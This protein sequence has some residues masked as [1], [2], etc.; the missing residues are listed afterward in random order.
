MKRFRSAVFAVLGLFLALA[1]VPAA[2]ADLLVSDLDTAV[3]RYDDSGA[4]VGVFASGGGLD[5]PLGLA[6]G[7]G[8]DLFVASN[9]TDQ[10]LRFDGR[11]GAFIGVFASDAGLSEPSGLAFGPD[12]DLY[13]ATIGLNQ[14]LRFDGDTGA[15]EGVFASGGGLSEPTGLLF[16]LDL[17]TGGSELFVAS[18]GSNEV[19]RYDNSG[20]FVCVAASGGGLVGPGGLTFGR[21]GNLLVSGGDEVLRFDS[22]TGAF[23]GV[24]ASGSGLV[25]PIGL[26]FGPGGDLFV[27]SFD[28]R[29]VLRFDGGTGTFEGVFASGGGLGSPTF[30]IFTPISTS[31]QGYAMGWIRQTFRDGTSLVWHN[32]GIDGFTTFIGFLPERD[33]GL[34]VLNNMNPVAIGSFFYL[35]VLNHLLS[36]R[37]GLN[38]GVNQR[39][40]A[41]Y[42]EAVA[43]TRRNLEA[44]DPCR[45][46][47]GGLVRR[48]LPGG[49]RLLFDEGVLQIRVGA[50]VMPLRALRDGAYVTT[51]GLI[52]GLPVRLTR[53]EGVARMELVRVETVTR[54][55][56][57]DASISRTIALNEST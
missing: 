7:P 24:F 4:F 1:S 42:D 47:C 53:T 11:T 38:L 19:L 2:R 45:S 40:D 48:V 27:S 12:G 34:V 32:G 3:L 56:G 25:A 26:V 54:T 37:F 20:A 23:R 9:G 16:R 39:I 30:L 18:N 29:Q 51:S 36:Q 50:R 13:V 6:F 15:F 52:P 22:E 28:S 55:V 31:I 57:L 33:L 35:A 8:G 5:S 10:V 41:A 49:Y 17:A 43:E 46:R 21:D 14:V 44:Y